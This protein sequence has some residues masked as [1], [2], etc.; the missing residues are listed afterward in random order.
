MPTVR[1]VTYTCSPLSRYYEDIISSN[2]D[3]L[4]QMLFAKYSTGKAY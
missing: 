1:I 3:G 2:S 4:A